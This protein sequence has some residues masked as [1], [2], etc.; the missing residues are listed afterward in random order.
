MRK[1]LAAFAVVSLS[2]AAAQPA[3]AQFGGLERTEVKEGY[4]IRPGQQN[5][6]V[7]RPSVSVGEQTTG[8]M[9]EPNAE[10]SETAKANL[11]GA[12]S[13]MHGANGIELVMVP[14]QEGEMGETVEEYTALFGTVAGAVLQHKM[15]YGNR[16]PTKKDS[17][18][19]TLGE[20][21]ARL[22]E[23]GGDYGLFF[24]TF[25]SY[26]STGRKV[27]QGLALV[28][29]GGFVPSGVHVGYAGLVDLENGDLVWLNIDTSMG[30]DP[31]TVEGAQKRVAQLME[32]F[33]TKAP[34][35]DGEEPA[36]SVIVL[37]P[38]TNDE[39]EVLPAED[40]ADQPAT[41]EED[42]E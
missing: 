32:E 16:L 30:G 6:L 7:F 20:D 26:G 35:V 18:D 36:G 25:D 33:P 17:F 34:D 3:V 22:K 10:W 11:I 28:L 15:T 13:Q 21:A 39:G 38:V 41:N 19:W 24:Y 40:G 5:I 31:R 27:L 9:N 29:G 42:G 2:L 12:L 23:L 37:P 8:G 14:D 1:I 4:Q